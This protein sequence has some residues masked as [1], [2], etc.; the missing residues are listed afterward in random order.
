MAPATARSNKADDCSHFFI[1]DCMS[2]AKC[3]E[4]TTQSAIFPLFTYSNNFIENNK[5]GYTLSISP[6]LNRFVERMIPKNLKDKVNSQRKLSYSNL[7]NN[8]ISDGII[9]I[10]PKDDF[11]VNGYQRTP[12]ENWELFSSLKTVQVE[13]GGNNTAF[14]KVE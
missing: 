4:R 10:S 14:I 3:G 5:G 2:E 11:D 7:V 8:I 12:E 6:E 1:S 13:A 9:E